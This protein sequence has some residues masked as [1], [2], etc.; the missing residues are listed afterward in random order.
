MN[1]LIYHAFIGHLFCKENIGNKILN[2]IIPYIFTKFL[3]SSVFIG[4]TTG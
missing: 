4:K 3:N 2:I 1:T